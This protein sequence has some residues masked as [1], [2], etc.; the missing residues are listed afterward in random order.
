MSPPANAKEHQDTLGHC[1]DL[2]G[3]II[4][5]AVKCF[6]TFAERAEKLQGK[7]VE[8]DRCVKEHMRFINEHTD[9]AFKSAFRQLFSAWANVHGLTKST[10]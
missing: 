2:F 7:P 10:V 5:G 1:L 3:R 8:F 6:R 4:P 9:D